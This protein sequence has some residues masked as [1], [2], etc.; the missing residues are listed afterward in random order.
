MGDFSN[1]REDGSCH[2]KTAASRS[3]R[4]SWNMSMVHFH[5]F[6]EHQKATS[7]LTFSEKKKGKLT[8]NERIE[9]FLGAKGLRS[10]RPLFHLADV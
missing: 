7:Y 5:H 1:K 2:L 10:L 9:Y 3:K 6:L 8:R 4:E